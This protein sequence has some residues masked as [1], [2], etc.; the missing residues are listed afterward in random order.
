LPV[1]FSC[2]HVYVRAGKESEREENEEFR[3][4]ISRSN[5]TKVIGKGRILAEEI[6]ASMV[7]IMRGATVTT[8]Q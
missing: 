6:T 2:G 1:V 8:L 3:A 4:D 7:G 5:G